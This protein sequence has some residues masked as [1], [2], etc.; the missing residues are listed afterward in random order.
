[1]DVGTRFF[2]GG[3]FRYFHPKLHRGPDS[4]CRVRVF[5]NIHRPLKLELRGSQ[6]ANKRTPTTP[7]MHIEGQGNLASSHKHDPNMYLV[8]FL[9]LWLT[10]RLRLS[11]KANK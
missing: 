10:A 6:R 5:D 9:P 7:L 8:S 4:H 1:M 3:A 11:A 2:K